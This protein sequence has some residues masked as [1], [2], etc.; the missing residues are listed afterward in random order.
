[1]KTQVQG[2]DYSALS[3]R[4]GEEVL[5][6]RLMAQTNLNAKMLSARTS[7][8]NT[9]SL[10]GLNNA[11]EA[12]LW[13]TGMKKTGNENFRKIQVCY[14]ETYFDHLPK[15]FDGFTILQ[16]TDLH[17]DGDPGLTD[18]IVE[19]LSSI[20]HYD[21]CA[22]TGDYRYRVTGAIEPCMNEMQK[23][24]QAVHSPTY[25]VLGNHD[26]VEMVPQLEELGA[27]VLLNESLTLKRNDERMYLLGVDDP[28][29]YGTHD[30]AA[31][32]KAIAPEEFKVL[33]V[34]SPEAYREAAHS[35]IDYLLCGHTHAGQVCLP[36]EVPI[37]LNTRC[38]RRFGC[39]AWAYGKMKGYTSRGTGGSGVAVRFFCPPEITIHKLRRRGTNNYET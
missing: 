35:Q 13:L 18:A 33:L 29:Y 36:G 27:R 30:I 14:E 17:I 10:Y 32:A 4:M 12:C 15:A 28:H 11:L 22:L 24:L 8:F 26:D 2:V 5:S 37:L 19:T 38:P 23:I 9:D 16:L 20:S 6:R 39:G 3:E 7:W 25:A 34:H 21:I 1:M 31:A